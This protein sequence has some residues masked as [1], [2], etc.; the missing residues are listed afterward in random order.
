MTQIYAV[1]GTK[2]GVGKTTTAANVGRVL[3]SAGASVVIIDADIEAPN[4]AVAFG[5][6]LDPDERT[7]HNVLAGGIQPEAAAYEISPRLR[8]VPG[9]TDLES[10]AAAD[11]ADLVG[12][13][14]AFADAE[15]VLIDS[16]AGLGHESAVPLVVADEV[17]LVSTP[18]QAA[19]IDTDKT[20]ELAERLD[21]NVSGVA[22]TRVP[23]DGPITH[24]ENHL[25]ADVRGEIPE[26]AAVTRAAIAGEPVVTF[27][28]ETPAAAAYRAL[29]DELTTMTIPG[30]STADD[31]ET[32]DTDRG[33]TGRKQSDTETGVSDTASVDPDDTDGSDGRRPESTGRIE[34][35][36]TEPP[37]A[38]TPSEPD[39]IVGQ[40][41]PDD[42]SE[43]T[44]PH[45]E[46]DTQSEPQPSD[47]SSGDESQTDDE[48]ETNRDE[49]DEERSGFFGRLLGG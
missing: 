28:P 14:N 35:T 45:R 34:P 36:E 5:L 21:A 23:Q 49:D 8:I 4:L 43:G 40:D 11:P 42:E 13:V 33:N 10:Y 37:T 29:A 30:S 44:T 19:L 6:D 24:I 27:A 41:S 31:S 7:V 2:G 9:S 47:G 46:G 32:G 15:Y 18:E 39:E 12:V 16:A 26:D 22:L 48:R 25:A 20:R 38:D 3:A 1:A 17:L